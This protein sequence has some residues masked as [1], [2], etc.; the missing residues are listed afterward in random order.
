MKLKL[1]TA[2]FVWCFA[3]A[4]WAASAPMEMMQ[5]TTSQ[6]LAALNANKATLKSK[7]AVVR[8]IMEQYLL[9]HVAL[10]TMA[11]SVLGRAAWNSATPAQREQFTQEFKRLLVNTYSS[12]L[13]N[14][15]NQT[16]QFLP[17]RSD[18]GGRSQVQINSKVI[19]NDGPPISVSYQLTLEGGA[20]K[21]YDFSVDGVSMLGSFRSQFS[22]ELSQSGLDALIKRLAQHNAQ[23]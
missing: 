14:Y 16:V 4:V 13:A 8:N 10:G 17:M 20:W 15:T 11:R 9:P 21:V 12:A 23:F 3:V 1:L 22:N 2:F 7:P 5:S 18:V 6:V 19:R